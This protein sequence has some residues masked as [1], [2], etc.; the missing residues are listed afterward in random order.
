MVVAG[1]CFVCRLN[2]GICILA[3]LL[4]CVLAASTGCSDNEADDTTE[5]VAE[6]EPNDTSLQATSILVGVTVLGAVDQSDDPRDF[7]LLSVLV[8]GSYTIT[9]SGF[10]PSDLDMFLYDRNGFLLASAAPDGATREIDRFLD[11]DAQY[12]IEV[13]AVDAPSTTAYT[14]RVDG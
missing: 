7:Y 9:L 10:G 4:C 11:A 6:D 3:T 12:V 2:T 8:D 13:R 5:I 1:P 14:L